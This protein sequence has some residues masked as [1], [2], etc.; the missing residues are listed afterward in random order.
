[1]K[2]LPTYY[3]GRKAK[4]GGLCFDERERMHVFVSYCTECRGKVL[5]T[6]DEARDFSKKYR[7]DQDKMRTR[8]IM[9]SLNKMRL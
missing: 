8:K 6:L 5:M 7:D 2:T 4:V 1:M 9:K 3:T